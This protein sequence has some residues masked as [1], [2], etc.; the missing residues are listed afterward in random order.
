M[1]AR[2]RIPAATVTDVTF[3]D[4]VADPIGTAG[5]VLGAVGLPLTGEA[6]AAMEAWIAQDRKRD[7]LPTHRYSAADFGLSPEQIRERF[8]AY[9]RRYL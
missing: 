6:T 3:I 2:D 8:D 9:I 5:R 4:A 7:A 1:A